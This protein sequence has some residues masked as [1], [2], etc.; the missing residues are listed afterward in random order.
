MEENGWNFHGHIAVPL[1]ARLGM[2][3]ELPEKGFVKKA[4]S[5]ECGEFVEVMLFLLVKK[6]GF[7]KDV[8]ELINDG[9]D[10]IGLP[11]SQI[12]T[13]VAR[14]LYNRFEELYFNADTVK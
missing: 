4:D 1:E 8:L 10:Y 3:S 2:I 5:I 14:A 13:N 6:Y 9:K 7:N 12:P 11:A